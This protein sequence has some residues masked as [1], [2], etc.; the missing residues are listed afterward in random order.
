MAIS[1]DGGT[2]TAPN[3]PANASQAS[4]DTT[5]VTV[6]LGGDCQAA[7]LTLSAAGYWKTGAHDGT[8]EW[9]YVPALTPVVLY[10]LDG[11]TSIGIK[12][13]TGTVTMYL[14]TL[15]PRGVKGGR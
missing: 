6:T 5:G 9:Q 7:V 11:K 2:T 12:A 15:S 1:W 10:E 14:R 4:I 13:E 8:G 3:A